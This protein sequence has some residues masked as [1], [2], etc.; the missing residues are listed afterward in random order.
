ML[1]IDHL[2]LHINGLKPYAEVW[3]DAEEGLRHDDERRDVKDGIWSQI[4]EIEPVIE[5]KPS[6][7]GIK[8][9]A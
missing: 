6:N 4:M 1:P 8:T 9:K 2:G 5:R 7:K 3:G